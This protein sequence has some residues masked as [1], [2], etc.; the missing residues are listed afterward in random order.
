MNPSLV[1]RYTR[2]SLR[3][4]AKAWTMSKKD[5]RRITN[6]GIRCTAGCTKL[7]HRHSDDVMKEAQL[8][9]EINFTQQYLKPM[10]EAPTRN[11]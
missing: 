8:E 9:T 4:F 5:V 7:Y 2:I 10:N 1:P 6:N 11:V 3:S